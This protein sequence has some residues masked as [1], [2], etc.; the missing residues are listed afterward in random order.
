MARQ[1]IHTTEAPSSPLYSQGIKV[2]SFVYV[3][4]MWGF[5]MATGKFAGPTIQ[6]Q[7]RQALINCENVLRAGGATREHVVEVHVLLAR[8]GDFAAFNEEYAKFFPV[9]PPIRYVS[10]L[11]AE[12]PGMLVSIKMTAMIE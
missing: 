10:K 11:G 9:D 7:A 6:E 5:D 12:L 2:G 3:T 8:P 1:V 4:G